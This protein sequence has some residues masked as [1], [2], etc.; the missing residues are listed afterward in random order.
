MNTPGK[1]LLGIMIKILYPR[2]H[3]Y[4]V[5]TSRNMSVF[6]YQWHLGMIQRY[7]NAWVKYWR[8]QQ[9]DFVIA[10]GFGCQA[11]RHTK[12]DLMGLAASYT[13]LWN[14]LDMS[15]GSIPVTTVRE[16]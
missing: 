13:F 9:L 7:R 6:D 10:P 8:E 11:V 1:F 15:V 14:M 4:F 3:F 12:S 16:D 5:E 2:I